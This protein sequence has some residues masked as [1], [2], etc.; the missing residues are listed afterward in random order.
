[1]FLLVFGAQFA[2][3]MWMNSRGF[4]FNDAI[5][6]ATNALFVL[7][8]SEPTLTAIGFVWMPLPTLI[9]LLWVSVYPLWPGVVSSGFASTL[10][11]A[12]AGGLTATILLGTG[13]AMGL[14]GL[15]GWLYTLAVV[16]NPMLF[17]YGANG[18][19]EGVAMPFLIGT[20]CCLLLFWH[21]GRRHYI[22]AGALALALGFASIYQAVHYGAALFAALVL[23]IL[24]SSEAKKSAPQGKLRAVEGLGLLFLVPSAFFGVLWILTNAAIM[25]EPFFFAQSQYSNVGYAE[26][27]DSMG[28]RGV[29]REVQGDLLGTI[30]FAS[31]R[32]APFLIPGAVL[33]LVRALDRRFFR[34]N[35]LSLVL[36]LLSVP[37]GLIT[38][39]IYQGTSFG[40]LRFFIYPL[41]VAAGWGLYEIVSSRSRKRAAGL[42]L[43]G[44]L[45]A[46]P[47]ILLAMADPQLG[48]EENG[49]V[50]GILTGKDAT[51]AGYTR[52]AGPLTQKTEVASDLDELPEGSLVAVDSVNGWAI[53]AQVSPDTLKNNLIVTH[54]SDFR[55][56]VRKPRA[57][58]VTH[59]L[60]PHPERY[61]NDLITGRWPKLYANNQPGFELVK[62]YPETPEKWHLYEVAPGSEQGK[63]PQ[64]QQADADRPQQENSGAKKEQAASPDKQT[65]YVY[66]VGEIQAKSVEAFL[67]SHE[68]L[69][70]YDAITSGD[71]EK[72]QANQAA[73]HGF[74]DQASDLGAPQ[75]YTDQKDAFLSAIQELHQASQL[76]YALA[77]DPI[78]ATQADFDHY[79]RLVNEAAAGLQQSNEILGKD[80]KTIEGVQGV[81]TL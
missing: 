57:H 13:R 1:M 41:F 26:M 14:S 9:E 55:A 77:A 8:G 65:T 34:V 10:T 39:L 74:A 42:V 30:W 25:G 51:E 44:W 43:A 63:P 72:M 64:R 60:V 49:V 24:W 69:L 67:D 19:S 18:M 50:Y 23:G 27:V 46:A 33:L 7:H 2:F 35:T 54:D 58:E 62:E 12:L 79:D 66:E 3:G 28:G 45:L 32:V 4:L 6:R 48:Q 59:L 47:V 38:P 70:R 22:A 52:A 36:L 37:I 31:V 21:T 5:S 73:L 29:A 40:W 11:T 76:A 71:I 56:A 75:K 68:K 15:Y 17:W 53:A 81:N 80:F 78:S 61:P 16:L 20:V